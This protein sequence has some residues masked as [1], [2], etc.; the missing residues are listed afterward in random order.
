MGWKNVK[1]HYGI[2]HFVQVQEKGICIGSAYIHD[3]IVIGPDGSLK[4]HD[5]HDC[6]NV[7]LRR[8]M[9]ELRADPDKLKQLVLSEDHFDSSVRVFTYDGGDIVEKLCEVPGW[10]N[11]THDGEMMFD[12]TFSLDREEVR[13]WAVE[14]AE[15]GV[16]IISERIEETKQELRKMEDRLIEHHR[17]LQTLKADSKKNP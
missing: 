11:V 7:E 8:Y 5:N 17:D 10:P 14:N 15:A 6:G 9:Q 3:I 2:K 4:K 16:K 1:E 13:R 12:N